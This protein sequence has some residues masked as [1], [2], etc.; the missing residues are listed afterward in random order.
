MTTV[1]AGTSQT[2]TAASDGTIFT[3]VASGGSCGAIS[4][5]YRDQVG[6][7]GYLRRFGPLGAGAQITVAMQSGFAAISASDESADGAAVTFGPDR[8][9]NQESVSALVNSG[10]GGAMSLAMTKV[11]LEAFDSTPYQTYDSLIALLNSMFTA[12][13][14][15]TKTDRGLCSDGVNR[16]YEY[17]AGSGPINILVTC[18]VHGPELAGTWS[19]IRWFEGFTNPKSAVFA[20]LRNQIT[21]SWV[22]HANPSAFRGGRKNANL[23]D[24]D[25]NYP[26]YWSKYAAAHPLTSDDNYPGASALSEPETQA[27]KAIIDARDIDGVIDC[28][29]YEVGYSS[30][31]ILTGTGSFWTRSNRKHWRLANQ[32]HK[33]VYSSNASTF[34]SNETD[35]NPTLQNWATHYLQNVRLK[36]HGNCALLECSRDIG[37]G[38]VLGAMTSDG[39]TRYAGYITTWIV[40]FLQTLYYQAPAP[41]YAWQFRRFTDNSGSSISAGGT[42]LDQATDYPLTWD[43]SDPGVSNLPR[44]YVD[45]PVT[46][47]GWLDVYFEGTIES[48]SANAIRYS[49]GVSLDGGAIVNSR[50]MSVTSSAVNGGRVTVTLTARFL[51]TTV[52]ATYVPRIQITANRLDA[53]ASHNLKRSRVIVRFVPN[54]IEANNYTP[55][56]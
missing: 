19:M 22:P 53:A 32:V 12:S 56:F 7:S 9:I 44:N 54:D 43:E 21:V 4:G 29:N 39:I 13:K 46:C 18:G 5:A 20:A 28:H 47:K 50:S 36:P 40:S 51:I 27:I 42:L 25:R 26:F 10:F 49:F 2:F 11:T 6:P 33:A 24:L 30:Y 15:V 1:N 38:D 23:V 17:R 31:E 45:C 37:G 16:I 48:L 8:L 34:G 52:D 55:F 14:G 41:S 35:T 3:V